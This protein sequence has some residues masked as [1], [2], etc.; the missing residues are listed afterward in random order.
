MAMKTINGIRYREEDVEL[1]QP[2]LEH[3]IRD[4]P[5]AKVM[6]PKAKKAAAKAGEEPA[7]ADGVDLQ[8]E[9]ETPIPEAE[10]E[11]S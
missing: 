1:F 4:K 6:R 9:A 3:A 5:R 8:E 10:G 2:V 11:S 7:E